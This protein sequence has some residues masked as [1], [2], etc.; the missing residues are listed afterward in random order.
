[1]GDSYEQ[2]P[3]G[4]ELPDRRR[5]GYKELEDK[6]DAHAK[7]LDNRLAKFIRRGLIAFSIIG[8]FT[9]L[10][11]VGFGL[12]LHEQHK[13][14]NLIQHQ[15]AESIRTGCVDQNRRH[16]NTVAFIIKVTQKAA[17]REPDPQTKKQI[18]AS[19][20][21]NV[22]LIQAIAPKQNCKALVAAAVQ[23]SPTP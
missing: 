23:N 14:T 13:T 7:A 12:V 1:M 11:L 18:L 17:D 10:S 15:R 8:V 16:D 20:A 19:Q 4:T 21:S 6:L 2:D 5:H 9:A 22:A 3:F